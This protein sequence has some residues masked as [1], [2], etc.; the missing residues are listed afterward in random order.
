[1]NRYQQFG[2]FDDAAYPFPVIQG[3]ENP[4]PMLTRIGGGDL[5]QVRAQLQAELEQ[6]GD[7]LALEAMQ[8]F[9]T[10][11]GD[12]QPPE[13]VLKRMAPQ[14]VKMFAHYRNT[15]KATLYVTDD[16]TVETD[17]HADHGRL[18]FVSAPHR[19]IRLAFL[20]SDLEL[21][22]CLLR[23]GGF[24]GPFSGWASCANS[25]TVRVPDSQLP[26][27]VGLA[28]PWLHSRAP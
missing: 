25:L 16:L 28:N 1:M 11:Y 21:I 13:A 8:R 3:W 27:K 18:H 19:G 4:L 2:V 14:L 26:P 7:P 9:S 20:P 23:A 12:A 5:A 10:L 22:E 15:G 24:E 6:R 17:H